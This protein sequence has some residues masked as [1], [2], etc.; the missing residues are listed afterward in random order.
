M[1]KFLLNKIYP[2]RVKKD[3]FYSYVQYVG[4]RGYA[5]DDIAGKPFSQID[6]DYLF[7][8]TINLIIEYALYEAQLICL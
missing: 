3:I 6:V 4:I 5:F 7:S 2:S 1:S 8:T